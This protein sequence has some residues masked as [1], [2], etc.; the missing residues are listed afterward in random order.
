MYL[1]DTLVNVLG[2]LS[3]HPRVWYFQYHLWFNLYL[4]I[5]SNDFI[6]C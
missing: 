5:S 3:F 4:G 2:V 1:I 6:E